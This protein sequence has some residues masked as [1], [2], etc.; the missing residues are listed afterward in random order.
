MKSYLSLPV[1]LGGYQPQVAWLPPP[2]GSRAQRVAPLVGAS[3]DAAIHIKP[4]WVWNGS[5]MALLSIPPVPLSGST[6]ILYGPTP[7]HMCPM[8]SGSGLR[9]FLSRSSDLRWPTVVSWPVLGDA[10]RGIPP[11]RRYGWVNKSASFRRVPL[12]LVWVDWGVVGFFSAA[13]HGEY[14]GGLPFWVV[15]VLPHLGPCAVGALHCPSNHSSE[16]VT[17]TLNILRYYDIR[18]EYF[19]KKVN[20]ENA[21]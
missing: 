6:G 12:A 14:G 7:S 21:P 19:Q 2:W 18:P 10:P 5:L 20:H 13:S 8:C 1:R 4:V 16:C 3:V 11:R 15:Q 17:R 9:H